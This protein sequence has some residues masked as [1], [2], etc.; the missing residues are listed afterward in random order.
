MSVV[1][2]NAAPTLESIAF[3]FILYARITTSLLVALT[4][5]VESIVVIF[6]CWYGTHMRGPAILR[7]N[8]NACPQC[9]N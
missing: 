5:C 2:P 7:L 4:D 9:V 8:R 6:D 1:P 3:P